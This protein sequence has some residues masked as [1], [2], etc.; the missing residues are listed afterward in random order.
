MIA[1]L[2]LGVAFATPPSAPVLGCAG[3]I[4]GGRPISESLP[5]DVE[6]GPIRFTGLERFAT[7]SRK[8]LT[9]RP[10]RRWA[11]IKAVPV[12]AAG[13]PVTVAVAPPDRAHLRLAWAGGSGP[14]AVFAPCAR[15]A[16]AFSYRGRVGDYTAWA[17]GFLVDGPGCRRIQ[18]WVR[19]RPRPLQRVLAFGVRGCR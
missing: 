2:I 19:G 8:E 3:R 16:R 7:A 9:P 11:T 15:S 18:V 4:E 10:G 13:A 12:V 5:S 6:I 17:G 1:L 14:A